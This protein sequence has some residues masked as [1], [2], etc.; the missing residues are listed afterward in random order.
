LEAFYGR[1]ENTP[2]INY[3]CRALKSAV[4]SDQ[5]SMF[6]YKTYEYF[7]L[8]SPDAAVSEE[9]KKYRRLAA[10]MMQLPDR[11]ATLP[12][13]S[14]FTMET[15]DIADYRILKQATKVLKSI[16]PFQIQLG[17]IDVFS[18]GAAKRSIVLKI[19]DPKPI[20]A[21]RSTLL[22]ELELKQ[23]AF[24][25]HITI[26]G[27]APAVEIK[28]LAELEDFDYKGAF[29]CRSVTVLRKVKGEEAHYTWSR[30]IDL[31][32]F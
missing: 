14:L 11:G 15:A 28:K 17:G 23:G 1:A 7:F 8:I 5:L 4:M 18:H 26:L 16:A 22:E 21:L 31:G 10:G 24:M 19:E 29:L 2:P 32:G 25:P 9:V 20:N 3:L 6:P 12:H 27:N 13:L 30:E